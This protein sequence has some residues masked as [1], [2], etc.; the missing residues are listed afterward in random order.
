MKMPVRKRPKKPH[1]QDTRPKEKPLRDAYEIAAKYEKLFANAYKN[2][3]RAPLS[4]K[5]RMEEFRD[6]V[7]R[8]EVG[9]AI[10]V[11][12]FL[13]PDLSQV[14]DEWMSFSGRVRSA[15]GIVMTESGNDAYIELG[16]PVRSEVIKQGRG[17]IELPPNPLSI[18]WIMTRSLELAKF[19][20]SSQQK[21]IR[22]ILLDGYKNGDRVEVIMARI[23]REIGLLP[24]EIKA[25]R[26]FER[27]MEES[28]ASDSSI[29]R[30]AEKKASKM[31]SLRAERIARTETVTAQSRGRQDAWQEA[32]DQGLIPDYIKR[33]W[34]AAST[35]PRTCVICTN[36]N[37]KETELTKP[38]DSPDIG[39]IMGPPAHPQ[40][41]CTVVLTNIPGQ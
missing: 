12:P 30:A 2:L 39:P 41:R 18:R 26:T 9:G 7:A 16:L 36:L 5:A 14:P 13:S 40:C 15:Y 10:R 27:K 31:L 21:A 23:K 25:I 11:L 35:S 3:S 22:E 1:W 20:S 29:A 33:Q 6:A 19:L 38:F 24:R 32:R 4:N 37:A 8:Q 28:G 17:I 34:I